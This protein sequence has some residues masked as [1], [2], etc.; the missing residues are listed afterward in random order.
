MSISGFFQFIFG[1]ILG[2]ILLVS[3][4]VG[5]AYYFFNRMASAPP[6]PVFSETI[7]APPIEE[8]PEPVEEEAVAE[9]T[10]TEEEEEE[11]KED[12]IPPGAYEAKVTWSSGLS[13]RSEPD[14]SASRIGGVAY[15]EEIL[16]LSETDDGVWQKARTKS[17]QEAWIKAGN[18]ERLD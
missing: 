6:K 9:G 8:T 10:E 15:N 3:G 1:F 2:V 11:E 4:S 13:L 14:L 17:G 18:V 5:A 12:E 16:I 7:P